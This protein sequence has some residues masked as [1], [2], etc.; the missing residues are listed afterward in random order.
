MVGI[1]PERFEDARRS[2]DADQA[3]GGVTFTPRST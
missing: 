1:R 3:A 2:I